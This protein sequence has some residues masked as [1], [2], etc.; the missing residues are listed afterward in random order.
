MR[1]FI[2][3]IALFIATLSFSQGGK[4]IRIKVNKGETGNTGLTG[5][6][7]ADG[8]DGRE[9]ELQNSGTYIQWRYVGDVSWTNLI[10]IVTITGA[11][12]SDGIDGADGTEIELQNSGT[13]IQWR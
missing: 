9:V 8:D 11:D 2:L 3:I 12:G 10:D 7:G 13:Y 5:P 6:S 1:Y 4:L